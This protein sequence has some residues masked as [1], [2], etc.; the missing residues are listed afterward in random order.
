[1]GSHGQPSEAGSLKYHGEQLED[2]GGAAGA[3]LSHTG[4]EKKGLP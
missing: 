1:M 3:T 2:A 4:E